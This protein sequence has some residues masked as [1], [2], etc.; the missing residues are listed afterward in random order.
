MIP[1]L[2]IGYF[3]SFPSVCNMICSWSYLLIVT[4]PNN[5]RNM[6]FYVTLLYVLCCTWYLLYLRNIYYVIYCIF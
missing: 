5:V 4:E 6:L 3:I 1:P 2:I